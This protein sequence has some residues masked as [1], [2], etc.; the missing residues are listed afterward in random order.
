MLGLGLIF[1]ALV[2][3][4][5]NINA[6]FAVIPGIILFYMAV[7]IDPDKN[8]EPVEYHTLDS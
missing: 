6:L 7:K 1:G 3:S 2:F 5:Q 8:S 4:T